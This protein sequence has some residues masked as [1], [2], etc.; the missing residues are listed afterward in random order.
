MAQQQYTLGP[1]TVRVTFAAARLQVRVQELWR[2]LFQIQPAPPT[3][4]ATIDLHFIPQ[5]KHDLF[6]T[7]AELFRYMNIGV[8][9]ST[10]YFL[11]RCGAT[12]LCIDTRHCRAT[13][14]L[15]DDFWHYSLAEQREFFQLTF[16]LLLRARGYYLLHANALGPPLD[17]QRLDPQA[18]IL[19]I[20]DSGVGKT[21]LTLSLLQSGWRVVGD[22]L[23]LLAAVGSSAV[24]VYGL[25]R[26]FSCTLQAIAAFP[27]LQPLVRA[28]SDLRRGKKYLQ[29]DT[30][31]PD[32]FIHQCAPQL[33][34][35]PALTDIA[36][37][38]TTGL[39]ATETMDLLLSQPRAGILV[40][41]PTVAGHLQMY[42]RLIRQTQSCRLLLGR[43]VF[44]DPQRVSRLL[45]LHLHDLPKES[46]TYD[47]LTID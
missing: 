15:A 24:T 25:R 33:L 29:L 27:D 30:R 1:V 17:A 18:G 46:R 3:A 31:Y 5:R 34:L 11:L 21:T 40:D 28:E 4:A 14:T 38:Q 42:G 45:Q 37:S 6:A 44:T 13:G 9:Q 36:I 8:F 2:L 47:Q 39:S 26:G 10:E 16:F 7:A 41:P 19:L 35:F 20:G 43:D 22:D 12:N 23:S 32:R